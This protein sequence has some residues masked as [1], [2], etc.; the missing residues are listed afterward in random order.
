MLRKFL[1]RPV[2]HLEFV[3]PGSILLALSLFSISATLL[4]KKQL[5][6]AITEG[7]FIA[8]LIGIIVSLLILYRTK[9]GTFLHPLLLI[10]YAYFVYYIVGWRGDIWGIA[11]SSLLIIGSIIVNT[12]RQFRYHSEQHPE[13]PQAL[14]G[15]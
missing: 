8:G 15:S 11:T 3:A 2:R 1:K 12:I 7:Y 6:A 9:I 4:T 14:R 13:T 10:P 5:S